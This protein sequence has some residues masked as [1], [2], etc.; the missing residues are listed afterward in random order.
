MKYI[1]HTLSTKAREIYDHKM[2]ALAKKDEAVMHQIE[3]GKDI[4]S[5]L[6]ASCATYLLKTSSPSNDSE[7]K[8]RSFWRRSPSG[9]RSYRADVVSASARL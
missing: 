7:S 1:I 9:G 6:S 4:I 2:T 8:P 5:V 3:E